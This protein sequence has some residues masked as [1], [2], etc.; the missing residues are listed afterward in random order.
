M[1]NVHA[2]LASLDIEIASININQLQW[3]TGL[4]PFHISAP[5]PPPSHAPCCKLSLSQTS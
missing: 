5:L 1:Q 4:E 3:M 2:F